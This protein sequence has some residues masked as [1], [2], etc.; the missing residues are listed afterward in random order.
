MSKRIRER[1]VAKK[2]FDVFRYVEDRKTIKIG[3]RNSRRKSIILDSVRKCRRRCGGNIIFAENI[4]WVN[5]T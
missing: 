2:R 4:V 1:I 5:Y 3:R